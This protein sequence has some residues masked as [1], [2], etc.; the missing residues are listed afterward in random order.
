MEW[1]ATVPTFIGLRGENVEW[2]GTW[3]E[4]CEIQNE[5]AMCNN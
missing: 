3:K 5:K 4:N 1:L 2:N